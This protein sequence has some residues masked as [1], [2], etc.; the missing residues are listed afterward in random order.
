MSIKFQRKA[1]NFLVGMLL[2]IMTLQFA[3]LALVSYGLLR[4]IVCVL[5]CLLALATALWVV[6]PIEDGKR[7][8]YRK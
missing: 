7:R 3:T 6:T 4:A 5:F 8:K 2:A 1:F